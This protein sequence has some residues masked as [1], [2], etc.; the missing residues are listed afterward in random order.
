[1]EAKNEVSKWVIIE[2]SS[3]IVNG[4]TN[5]NK[6]SCVILPNTH[7]DTIIVAK[8]SS[9]T[10]MLKGA[11]HIKINKFDCSNS[12]MTRELKRTLK[13]I[14]F[15]YLHIRF[16]SLKITNNNTQTKIIKGEVEIELAGKAKCFQVEY[17]LSTPKNQMIL[18]GKQSINFSDFNL[19]PPTKMGRLIK[20]KDKLQVALY[21]K[22]EQI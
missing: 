18:S 11:I 2:N 7:A 9:G 6:F 19:Q 4:L 12:V 14:E 1:M 16:L 3:L 20:A 8:N 22:M 13:E 15:P 5:V 10:S 21:L 17:Q